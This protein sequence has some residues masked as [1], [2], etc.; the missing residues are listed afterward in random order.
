MPVKANR[1][2]WVAVEFTVRTLHDLISNIVSTFQRVD[3]NQIFYHQISS[4]VTQ[5]F[6]KDDVSSSSLSVGVWSPDDLLTS[7]WCGAGLYLHNHHVFTN[8]ENFS[9]S[10]G[11]RG[12]RR[13]PSPP[14]SSPADT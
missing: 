14:T 11:S 13:E 3:F 2:D 12:M 9:S 4:K 7:V 10:S 5:Y 6:H 8:N 1:R